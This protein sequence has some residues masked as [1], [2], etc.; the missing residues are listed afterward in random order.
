MAAAS[1]A[2]ARGDYVR[3]TTS[4][5]EVN[6]RYW[7]VVEDAGDDRMIVED[8]NGWRIS[9]RY[10]A[11]QSLA[12]VPHGAPVPP[13]R[14]ELNML[15]R[16]VLRQGVP[17]NTWM[18]LPLLGDNYI[19]VLPNQP[20]NPAYNLLMYPGL[21]DYQV[22]FSSRWNNNQTFTMQHADVLKQCPAGQVWPW[23][24]YCD[25]FLLPPEAHRCSRN[26]QKMLHWLRENSTGYVQQQGL[27]NMAKYVHPNTMY[28]NPIP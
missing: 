24:S 19:R 18:R 14:E 10:S 22:E 4:R 1:A 16:F 5:P 12:L 13:P 25:R 8:S 23:C 26:H 6:T 21:R 9:V 7:R 17:L 2:F 15:Q 11:A 27:S 28:S 20:A 3:L